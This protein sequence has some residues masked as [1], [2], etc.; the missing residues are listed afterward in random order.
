MKTNT[1]THG[2]IGHD[3]AGVVAAKKKIASTQ[4]H[5]GKGIVHIGG[6][7]NSDKPNTVPLQPSGSK[8]QKTISTTLDG[9]GKA[10][11][12]ADKVKEQRKLK[13]TDVDIFKPRPHLKGKRK[14][15]PD[16]ITGF[17]KGWEVETLIGI[18]KMYE[19]P[20]FL[21][22]WRGVDEVTLVPTRIVNR[23]APQKVIRYYE[24]HALWMGDSD[25]ESHDEF[26]STSDSSSH[27]NVKEDQGVI[28]SIDK[29]VAVVMEAQAI[30][31]NDTAA[32]AAPAVQ[33]KGEQVIRIPSND[34]TVVIT[35]DKAEQAVSSV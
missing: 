1:H 32:A 15:T 3:S 19:E 27:S 11:A 29:P 5:G 25:A 24:K 18:T 2:H 16:E 35:R 23:K 12:V 13:P 10:L 31:S 34:E 30:V 7:G 4:S 20:K 26:S 9:K 28:S 14:S 22:K 8:E 17:D 33:D 6:G 21:I